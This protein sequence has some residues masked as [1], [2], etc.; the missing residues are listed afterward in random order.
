[1]DPNWLASS[2]TKAQR[3]NLSHERLKLIDALDHGRND[4]LGID[5]F[6]RRFW[7]TSIRGLWRLLTLFAPLC[8]HDADLGFQVAK[9]MIQ[10]V[11][12]R[13]ETAKTSNASRDIH[14][15]FL[16]F[17]GEPGAILREQIG[18]VW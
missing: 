8:R 18:P 1:V 5:W 2:E 7:G 13:K 16:Y 4:N 6:G 3:L 12:V 11:F 9:V 17:R 10:V 15:E 14:S